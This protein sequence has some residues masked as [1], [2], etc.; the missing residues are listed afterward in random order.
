MINVTKLLCGTPRPAN[1]FC[2][3]GIGVPASA[4]ERKPAIIWD[5]T[6]RCNLKC[7]HCY[8]DSAHKYYP[9]ELTLAQMVLSLIHI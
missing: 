8:S 5:I 2:G 1:A 6:R 3:E 4:S 7:A 9:G